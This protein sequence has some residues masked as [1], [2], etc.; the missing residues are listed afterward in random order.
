MTALTDIKFAPLSLRRSV[1]SVPC[2]NRRALEKLPML[3][4]DAVIFDLEDSVAPEKKAEARENLRQ[5]FTKTAPT[6]IETIVR[7][8]PLSSP[9]GPEDMELVVEIMPDAVLIPKV[10]HVSDVQAVADL[11]SDAGMQKEISIWAMIETP[12]GVLN[13]PAIALADE[14][15]RCFVVGLNDLRKATGVLPE[16][17]RNYL[18]P[19]LMQVVL[20]GRAQGMD[21]IDSVFN[22]FRSA[23]AFEAECAQGRS[24][25][26]D[27]KMLIHPDQIEPAN[28]HFGPDPKAVREAENIVAA[29]A[30]PDADGLNV[31]N[32]DGKM[33]ER[34][35]LAEAEQLLATAAR[36]AARTRKPS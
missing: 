20:A 8:N 12:K 34:L 10:E 18:V 5:F 4:T 22:D 24:M 19:W 25:G 6:G 3:D 13:A 14:R 2:V 26:F 21:V 9:F 29:F 27:G 33:V 31:I 1:L 15:L 16:P 35:H 17:G 11:I 32:L 30:R 7:I 23:D 36:I 28:R